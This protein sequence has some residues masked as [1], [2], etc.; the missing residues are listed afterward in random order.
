MKRVGK[1]AGLVVALATA[2]LALAACGGGT[3]NE[4]ASSS[5]APAAPA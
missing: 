1:G 2:G 3:V 5:A 4:A